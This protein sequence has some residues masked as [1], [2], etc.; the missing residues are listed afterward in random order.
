MSL[1]HTISFD[2]RNTF[3]VYFKDQIWS[4]IEKKIET[5]KE[6]YGTMR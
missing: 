2:P 4:K 5:E 3:F 1:G 6:G